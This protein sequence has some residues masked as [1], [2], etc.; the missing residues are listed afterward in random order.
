[1]KPMYPDPNEDG[2][3]R[4]MPYLGLS[5]DQVDEL[6]AYLLTLNPAESGAN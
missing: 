2:L 1:M 3:A 6:V 4:G 5:A